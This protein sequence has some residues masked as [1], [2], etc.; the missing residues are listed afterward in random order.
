MTPLIK[1]AI[2]GMIKVTADQVGVQ[3]DSD[4]EFD[5]VS[6]GVLTASDSSTASSVSKRT[7]E[8]LGDTTYTY[9]EDEQSTSS[10]AVDLGFT[11]VNH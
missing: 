11:E 5:A 2:Q 1:R 8:S 9:D 4:Q 7:V 6:G 3:K 10:S